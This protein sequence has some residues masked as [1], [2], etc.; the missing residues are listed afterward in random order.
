MNELGH[1][2]LNLLS[3]V[4][5]MLLAWPRLRRLGF[6]VLDEIDG[7]DAVL[8]VGGSADIAT[9]SPKPN[10]KPSIAPGAAARKSFMVP[11]TLLAPKPGVQRG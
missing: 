11:G 7:E 10:S 8:I 2:L 9:G 4:T 1:L 6:T 3:G 5:L